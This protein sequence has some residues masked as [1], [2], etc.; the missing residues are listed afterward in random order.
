MQ[1][2]AN[3]AIEMVGEE[4]SIRL[5]R[6]LILLRHNLDNFQERRQI[7]QSREN[8]ERL[9]FLRMERMR[10]R[11]HHNSSLPAG[12]QSVDLTQT[13]DD[14]TRQNIRM[15]RNRGTAG[16]D[17]PSTSRREPGGTVQRHDGPG[18]Y[19]PAEEDIYVTEES[20]DSEDAM[21]GIIEI[22]EGVKSLKK[23]WKS[24]KKQ[25]THLEK[26]QQYEMEAL[27]Q[28]H[29]DN[30]KELRRKHTRDINQMESDQDKQREEQMA[31]NKTELDSIVVR[32]AEE[33][34]SVKEATRTVR[35]RLKR[36]LEGEE[37]VAPECPLCMVLMTPPKQIY[38]CPEG[39]LV[40]SDCRPQVRDNLC[41]SCRSPQGYSSRC[42]YIE[43]IVKKK[44]QGQQ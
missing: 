5:E 17:Q 13:A 19:T 6:E 35:V 16:S 43:D 9:R 28:Q 39:H 34:R 24:T 8:R 2:N 29:K 33:R 10:R 32:E 40:C 41:A 22:V 26:K 1:V 3:T 11:L 15:E 38:Q 30:L 21:D 27:V 12:T 44:M 23:K 36:K 14:D 7:D 18:L 25:R 4:Q 37:S 42:R 20:D 31:R